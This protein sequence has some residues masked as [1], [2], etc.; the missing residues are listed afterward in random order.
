MI[1]SVVVF[2]QL[3]YIQNKKLGYNRDQVVYIPYQRISII[4]KTETIRNELL[5]HPN[6]EKVSF[7]TYMPLNMI[8]QGVVDEW[9]GNPTKEELP[10]YRNYVDEDFLDL[11]EIELEGGRNFSAALSTDSTESYILN[12]VA[13]EK[14][15]WASPIGKSFGHG[16]VIGVME[17]FHFQ[18]FSLAI[19][20][21][22]MTFHNQ[23]NSFYLGNIALKMKRDE[24]EQTLAY[25]EKTVKNILPQMPF[26]PR[27]MDESYNQ[28]YQAEHR[29]GQAFN[30]FTLI[31]FFI[32]CIGLFGLVTHHVFQRTKEIGIR[33]VLGA[34]V[35]N[36]VGMIS[37]DYL[38]L[39]L[40][41]LVIAI[42]V[43]Y[44]SM[45]QWLQ[46]FAYRI[47]IQWWIFLVA[48][49]LAISIAF[50]TISSQSLKAALNDPVDSIKNE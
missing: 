28:L 21:M 20:P 50:L 37:K 6:I 3:N 34:S 29:F 26:D 41:A 48:G 35:T 23:H 7:P 19:E 16:R 25:V 32:A 44:W 5:K 8:S 15:G 45:N 36:I 13:V 18:P 4:D 1:G 12:K 22:F 46:D 11:F 47:E 30:I 27:F 38:K 33:K 9:E 49:V 43:A 24:A 31:A 42:P 39:V 2:Q 14:L 40:T 10:I 17:N